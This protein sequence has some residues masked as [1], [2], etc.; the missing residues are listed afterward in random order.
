MW[1][2][3]GDY[4]VPA[5]PSSQFAP[6]SKCR[7]LSNNCLP[8]LKISIMMMM[9]MMRHRKIHFGKL[10]FGN[11]LWKI[12]FGKLHFEKYKIWKLLSENKSQASQCLFSPPSSRVVAGAQKTFS[13]QGQWGT[14]SGS[15]ANT[16]Y[17]RRELNWGEYDWRAFC[18]RSRRWRSKRLGRR[19]WWSW[20]MGPSPAISNTHL[21]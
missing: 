7:F 17:Q 8:N 9:T 14:A 15:P 1:K 10:Q 2:R 11:T 21:Q 13:D 6:W 4:F 18:T 12:P 3:W 20:S 5:G 19:E 16:F